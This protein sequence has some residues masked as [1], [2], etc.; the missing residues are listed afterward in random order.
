VSKRRVRDVIA[1]KD[2]VQLSA[3]A[4]VREA[5]RLMAEQGVGAVVIMAGEKIEGIFTE[6][7]ALKRVLAEGRDSD[8]TTLA[9]VM[10]AEIVTLDPDAFALDALRLMREVGIRHVPIVD[11]GNVIGMISLRDFVGAE[12]QQAGKRWKA[13]Q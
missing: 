10:T 5:S 7:D 11:Q 9:E 1:R 6:R 13:P 3:T 4:T 12:L 2:V 8:A